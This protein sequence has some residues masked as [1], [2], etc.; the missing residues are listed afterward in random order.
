MMNNT[1]TLAAIGG[2]MLMAVGSVVPADAAIQCQG[3]TQ[4]NSAADAWISSPYCEDNLIAAVAR[5]HGMKVSNVAVR[6]N[7]NTK[8]EACRFAGS[9][10]KISDLCSG[11]MY[12]GKRHY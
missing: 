3:R 6:Q 1:A 12:E 9:D 7:P 8:A 2:A 10:I 11:H 5:S 4:W